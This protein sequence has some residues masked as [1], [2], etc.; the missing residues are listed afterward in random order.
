MGCTSALKKQC[1]QTN[2]FN[3]GEQV[4]MSGKR[5]TGDEFV[6]SCEKEE[7][8]VDH[9]ALDIGFKK[10]MSKYCEA[11]TVFQTGK[12][13]EFFSADMCDNGSQNMLKQKHAMGVKEYCHKENGYHAGAKG[14]PY[15][16]ICPKGMEKDFV[17]EFNR[18]RKAYLTGFVSSKE[19]EVRDL[20]RDIS[21]LQSKKS[22]TEHEARLLSGRKMPV[23]KT[24]VD[25]K[26]GAVAHQ[27][28]W[29]E[30]EEAKRKASSLE[31]DINQMNSQINSKQKQLEFSREELRKAKMELSVL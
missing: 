9:G 14:K 1:E 25:P 27:T 12:K 28:D 29:V 5:L 19:D 3:Y 11:E 7:A 17:P 22:M 18:G 4:A 8:P 16:Q 6:M 21:N 31:W 26:T 23:T 30:D 24:V 10:G 15:N 2:W 20:E 13:G